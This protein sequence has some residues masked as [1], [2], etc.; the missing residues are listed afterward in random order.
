[1]Q[2]SLVFQDFWLYI[3]F[4]LLVI[5]ILILK[6]EKDIKATFR[7]TWAEKKIQEVRA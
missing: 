2:F 7:K 3:L 4:I 5:F 6:R 1:M